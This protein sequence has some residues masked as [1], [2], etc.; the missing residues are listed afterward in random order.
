M[1][2]CYLAAIIFGNVTAICDTQ[3]CIMRFVHLLFREVTVI[4]RDKRNIVLIGKINQSGFNS[5][6][7]RPAV[8]LQFYIKPVT[9]K[10]FEFLEYVFGWLLLVMNQILRHGSGQ[11]A[12]KAD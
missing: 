9:E 6:L 12:C 2:C 5:G 7:F 1:L 11:T 4:R 3:Q 10:L 8:T